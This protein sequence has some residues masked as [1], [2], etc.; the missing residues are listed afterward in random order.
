[1]FESH[2][3]VGGTERFGFP[4][5]VIDTVNHIDG[6]S[7][8]PVQTFN[9]CPKESFEREPAEEVADFAKRVVRLLQSETQGKKRG[10]KQ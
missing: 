1:L 3:A 2:K 5:L 10:G 9:S 6:L 4:K 8:D 7:P